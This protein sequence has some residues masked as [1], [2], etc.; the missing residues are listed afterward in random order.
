MTSKS[1]TGTWPFPARTNCI[2]AV[3]SSSGSFRSDYPADADD[4]AAFFRR[5]GA[6]SRLK[7]LLADRG[8]LQQWYEFEQAETSAALRAWCQENE[9][10]PT[11]SGDVQAGR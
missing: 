3:D 6:Y 9:I 5:K 7:I 1:R 2:S 11:D 8:V 10:E 4:V